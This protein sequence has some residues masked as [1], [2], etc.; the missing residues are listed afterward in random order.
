[1]LEI[2]R[3]LEASNEELIVTD[4]GKPVLKIIPLRPKSSVE[5]LFGAFQLSM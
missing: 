1:M 5:D 2:F 4:R 3:Q